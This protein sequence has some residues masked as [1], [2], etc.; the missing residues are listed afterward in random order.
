MNPILALIDEDYENQL[1]YKNDIQKLKLTDMYP[2]RLFRYVDNHNRFF[3][4]IKSPKTHDYNSFIR[5]D[6]SYVKEII[7]LI[8][9]T[10][11][12]KQ[13]INDDIVTDLKFVIIFIFQDGSYC[14][15]FNHKQLCYE[16]T[17]NS[18]ERYIKYAMFHKDNLIHVDNFMLVNKVQNIESFSIYEYDDGY[19]ETFYCKIKFNSDL[20]LNNQKIAIINY[21]LSESKI[22]IIVDHEPYHNLIRDLLDVLR[23]YIHDGNFTINDIEYI[24]KSIDFY[25]FKLI[26]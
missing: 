2:D 10:N 12:P 25:N 8:N 13:N 15:P 21:L 18:Q 17:F 11:Q 19:N 3:T 23:D 14:W 5:L 22:D 24:D 7:K 16:W 4:F 26:F 6:I 20:S 9:N 1:I